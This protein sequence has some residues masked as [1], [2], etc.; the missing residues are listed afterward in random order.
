MDTDN[1]KQKE[2]NNILKTTDYIILP[3]QRIIR[4]RVEKPNIFPNGNNFYKKLED[5]RLGFMKIY[6]TPCDLFCKILY[7]GD[8]IYRYEETTSVFDRP[9]VMIF[10][11]EH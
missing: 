4:D 7:L 8:P 5:G 3:S 2:L 6:E 9:T 11:Y 10:K 1:N